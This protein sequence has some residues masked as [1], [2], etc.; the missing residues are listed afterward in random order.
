VLFLFCNFDTLNTTYLIFSDN[1]TLKQN[2][3]GV[4]FALK[5]FWMK[6]QP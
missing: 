4:A 6:I 3:V 1:G 5:S 2:L